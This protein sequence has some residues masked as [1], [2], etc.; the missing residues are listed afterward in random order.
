MANDNITELIHRYLLNEMKVEEKVKFENEMSSN[1]AV[2]KQLKME[3]RFLKGVEYAADAELKTT[4][5]NVHQD[6]KNKGFFKEQQNHEAKIISINKRNRFRNLIAIAAALAVLIASWF[7]FNKINTPDVNT[8][9]IYA[10]YYQQ[11]KNITNFLLDQPAMGLVPTAEKKFE[12][13]IEQ[14]S[15]SEYAKAIEQLLPLQKEFP[16]NKLIPFYLGLS[17]IGLGNID[18]AIQLLTPLNKKEFEHQGAVKWYLSL[19]L[20]NIK[21]INEAKVLLNELIENND[22]DYSANAKELLKELKV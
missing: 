19:S 4:I 3:Q 17:N 9:V 20:I 12:L 13:A 6:L 11:E 5:A 21:R 15:F 18:E 8:D 10:N 2:K 22:P 1:E 14:Y 16:D 7:V